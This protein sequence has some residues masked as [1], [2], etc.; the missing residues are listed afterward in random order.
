MLASYI[1]IGQAIKQAVPQI[2]W[3][4]LD[5]G[6]LEDPERFNSIGVPGVLIGQSEIDWQQ[7]GAGQQQGTGTLTVKVVLRL[8]TQTHLTD[9]LLQDSLKELELGDQ[10]NTAVLSVPG[11]KTLAHYSDYPEGTFYVLEHTY[12]VSFKRGPGIT[13]KTVNVQLNP[14]LHNPNNQATA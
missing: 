13:Y 3:I 6:Q 7:L 5:K 4:D 14:Q 12:Q 8:P 1:I 10:I 9:P 11:I 2:Q